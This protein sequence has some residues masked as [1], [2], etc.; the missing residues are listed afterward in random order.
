MI[1]LILIAILNYF[2]VILKSLSMQSVTEN[3]PNRLLL[4]LNTC[5]K[6][7]EHARDINSRFWVKVRRQFT[8]IMKL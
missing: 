3:I 2:K 5:S 8:K 6:F 4:A 1:V 7:Q